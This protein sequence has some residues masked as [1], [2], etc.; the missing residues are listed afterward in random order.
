MCVIG[1]GGEGI[2]FDAVAGL[3][4]TSSVSFF[5]LAGAGEFV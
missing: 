3:S 4:A 1:E 2:V 5:K